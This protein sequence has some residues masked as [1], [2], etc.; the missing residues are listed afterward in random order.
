MFLCTLLLY[1]TSF[2]FKLNHLYIL[3]LSW[4]SNDCS[5]GWY[6]WRFFYSNKIPLY[7]K[8][9]HLNFNANLLIP[10]SS[11]FHLLCDYL[12]FYK[13][14]APCVLLRYPLF[15]IYILFFYHKLILIKWQCFYLRY[16]Y[17][18]CQ[19][20]PQFVIT[21]LIRIRYCLEIL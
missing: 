20:G 5:G 2:T 6:F 16:I 7:T 17:W 15:Y 1:F 18:V 8:Y 3:L 14:D 11:I 9:D 10:E 19:C 12:Q 21:G 13:V 4:I